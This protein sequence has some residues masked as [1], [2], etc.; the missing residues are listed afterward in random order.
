VAESSE[1]GYGSKTS[2]LPMSMMMM[3]MMMM[4]LMMA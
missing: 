1:K 2:V 3:M 4:M